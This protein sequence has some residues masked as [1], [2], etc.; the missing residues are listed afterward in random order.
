VAFALGLLVTVSSADSFDTTESNEAS[1]GSAT[2]EDL[3]LEGRKKKYKRP[4]VV[5]RKKLR[6]TK[7][8]KQKQQKKAKKNQKKKAPVKTTDTC[9][10]GLVP[11]CMKAANLVC[12]QKKCCPKIRFGVDSNEATLNPATLR[13]AGVRFVVRY[14]SQQATAPMTVDEVLFWRAQKMDLVAVWEMGRLRPVEG[15]SNAANFANGVADAKLARSRMKSYGALGRPVYF[16]VDT[17]IAPKNPA[18]LPPGT[19]INSF[20][21][22]I[23][24]FNGILSVLPISQVGAYGPYTAIKGLL[25]RKKIAWAWQ[26]SSF[27]SNGRLDPR[28]HLYQCSTLPPDTFGSGQL[29]YDFALTKDFGQWK[30]KL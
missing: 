21:A 15:G 30:S 13:A 16:A 20:N 25:D 10:V 7:Q 27:D 11:T 3:S 28:S 5:R 24:Y 1:G 8:R 17:F 18:K 19:V 9:G 22:I 4:A 6:A 23:P 29:D 14:I 26:A 2:E 12:G